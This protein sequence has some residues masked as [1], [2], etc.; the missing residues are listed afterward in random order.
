[1]SRSCIG[2]RDKTAPVASEWLAIPNRLFF[3]HERTR[4]WGPGGVAFLN[5]ISEPGVASYI[6]MYRIT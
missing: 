1:M 2:C 6:R 5:P 3:G 4:M